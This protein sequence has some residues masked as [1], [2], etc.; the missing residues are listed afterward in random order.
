MANKND[1]VDGLETA[2]DTLE[3]AYNR[4]RKRI[5]RRN[6]RGL[7]VSE[8]DRLKARLVRRIAHLERVQAE[9][10]AARTVSRAPTLTEIKE[11][12]GHIRILRSLAVEDAL[13]RAGLNAIKTAITAAGELAKKSG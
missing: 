3:A 10:E 12:A 11:T 1:A 4:L 7:D 13:T 9:L 8:E 5:V 6:R 2:I